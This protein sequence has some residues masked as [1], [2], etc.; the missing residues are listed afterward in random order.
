MGPVRG[1]RRLLA[2]GAIAAALLALAP[3]T[4]G[5]AHGSGAEYLYSASDAY[6]HGRV[7]EVGDTDDVLLAVQFRPTVGG[8][9]NGVRICLDLTPQQVS[10]RLPLA[11]GLWAADGQALANGG[12]YE[13]IEYAAPCFYRVSMSPVR[14]NAGR[15]YV[16]GFWLRGGQYSYVPDGF[17]EQRGNTTDGHLIAPSSA[18]ATVGDGNGLYAYSPAG[19]PFP[20]QSWENADYL[21]SPV[22]TPDPH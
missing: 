5:A 22:F 10:A 16:A 4:P 8:T 2:V 14:V 1:G 7:Q 21:V 18:D 12:A 15:T 6:L 3:V 9:V 13:G 17:A 11:A 20:T 19:M